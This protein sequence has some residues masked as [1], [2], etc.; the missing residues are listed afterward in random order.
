M[1]GESLEN[2]KFATK[3][4]LV[5]GSEGYGISKRARLTHLVKDRSQIGGCTEAFNSPLNC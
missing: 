2:C 5:L 1:E 4:A 3:K